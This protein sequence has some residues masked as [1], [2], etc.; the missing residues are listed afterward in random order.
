M[1][2]A[3]VPAKD[4]ADSVGATVHALRSVDGVDRV[5]VVDDGSADATAAAAA[6]AGADVLRLPDNRG[7]GGAVAAGVAACPDAEVFLLIDAD[8]ATTAAAADRLLDPVLAGDADLVIGVL[9]PAARAGRV[10]CDQAARRQRDPARLWRRAPRPTVRSAGDQ[11]RPAAG[12]TG[13]LPLRSRS[14][15]DDRRRPGRRRRR[16]GRGADGA[17]A[18]GSEHPRLRPPRSAGVR[19]RPCPVAA[20]NVVPSTH[21]R[22]HRRDAPDPCCRPRRGS[23]RRPEPACRRRPAPSA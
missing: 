16:R 7:K 8:L 23:A 22:H 10:R 17:P 15:D 6:A 4:R 13:D 20:A 18:H 19:H 21:R 14:G 12:R 11:G 5:L 1:I 3:I 9:P 2:V